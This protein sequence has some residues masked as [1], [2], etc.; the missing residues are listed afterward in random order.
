[1][2]RL[3]L[4]FI[5]LFIVT[6]LTLWS[7]NDTIVLKNKD[8]LV[9]EIKSMDRGIVTIETD[10]S[11]SDFTITWVDIM[12]IKSKQTY[13]MTLSNGTRINSSMYTKEGDSA[14]VTLKGYN[15]EKV[16]IKDIVYINPVKKKFLSRIVASV[17]LGYNIT[18]SNNLSQLSINS[19]LSYTAY[20]WKLYGSYNQVR[21][22]QD[23]VAATDR[24]DASA[25]LKYFMKNDWFYS[26][27][28]D[29]LSNDEQKLQLRSTVKSGLGKYVIHSN[30]MYFGGGFGLAFNNEKFTDVSNTNRNSLEAYLGL[31]L[32]VFDVKDFNL[33]TDITFYPSL[34]QGGRYRVDY[35][36]NLKYDLPLDFFIKL[37]LTYNYDSK[38]VEGASV[39]DYVFQSTFGWEFN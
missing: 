30:K 7:Q 1:M 27:S 2:K 26:F 3:K 19:N 21:S 20:K 34:T 31:A 23:S 35:D 13:L 39:S 15:N 36:L 16:R 10:Y 25:G 22:N 8:K 18:K 24:M 14:V 5:L 38:P 4:N 33:T 17:S 12:S 6:P 29:F 37:G 9:G 32:D 28:G 11:D